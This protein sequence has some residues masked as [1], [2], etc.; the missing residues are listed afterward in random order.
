[1]KHIVNWSYS[2]SKFLSRTGIRVLVAVL[3][4]A[5]SVTALGTGVSQAS[6]DSPFATS[7]VTGAATAQP[8]GDAPVS[9]KPWT[10]PQ[11]DLDPITDAA[12]KTKSYTRFEVH[13][14]ARQNLSGTLSV[15][16]D[17]FG[18]EVPYEASSGEQF[19]VY[20]LF[21]EQ[22]GPYRLELNSVGQDDPVLWATGN[23]QR[24]GPVEYRHQ[25]LNGDADP[26]LL[27]LAAEDA[28]VIIAL[29]SVQAK[30]NS[31]VDLFSPVNAVFELGVDVDGDGLI[32]AGE[33]VIHA[34]EGEASACVETPESNIPL[35][36]LYKSR[37][38]TSQ[39]AVIA[40]NKGLY[41]FLNK[42]SIHSEK[43][44]QAD[45]VREF[46]VK[47]TRTPMASSIEIMNASLR[48]PPVDVI[49]TPQ[50]EEV[51]GDII[52]N[53]SDGPSAPSDLSG[54]EGESSA[55]GNGNDAIPIDF[56]K[57]YWML[58]VMGAGLAIAALLIIR[59]VMSTGRPSHSNG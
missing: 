33:T 48:E 14:E 28:G 51:T 25:L 32:D 59:G 58:L 18:Q 19:S 13:Q 4:I 7:P 12:G 55:V 49:I 24:I 47:W 35:T 17:G 2:Q 21:P 56:I 29:G 8:F 41:D 45:L 34:I 38:S 23:L 40:Q 52:R 44:A 37:V 1:M 11:E 15:T 50:A 10:T 9:S 26:N 53:G 5:M 3:V 39:G 31:C 42:S 27:T 36:S 30:L 20:V 57:G 6:A 22:T 16:G 54:S 43:E 46:Q